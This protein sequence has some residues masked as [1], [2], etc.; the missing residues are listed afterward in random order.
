MARRFRSLRARVR[1][2]RASRRGAALIVVLLFVV[3]MGALALSATY[4]GSNATMISK[5]Y[6][7][8][9]DLR[10][11]AEAAL[12]M[13]KSKVNFD[14]DALPDSGYATFW[15]NVPVL[16]AD[17]TPVPG[18]K[19]SVY[20]GPSGSTSGQ[21]GRF[22]SIVAT[23]RDAQNNLAVRRLELVQESFAKFAYWSNDESN[24]GS[25]IY[26][27]NGD[28]LWGPV[29]SND[30]ISIAS[31]GATF[32]D[33]V[34]TAKS[35][36]GV[37]YGVF[38]KGYKTNQQA[39]KLPSTTTLS[40]LSSYAAL[41]GF[42]FAPAN[43]GDETLV[44]MRIEFV[45]LDLNGDGDS[46]DVDEGF[47]R[48]YRVDAA[49]INWL[50]ADWPGTT[51]SLVRNCGDWHKLRAGSSE[52]AFFPASVHN[53]SWFKTYLQTTGEMNATAA[54]NES[55][56]S[57]GTI[58]THANARCYLGGDPHLA[59]AARSNWTTVGKQVGGQDT[60]FTATEQ[61]GSWIANP[62]HVP[63][64]LLAV[65]PYDA[66][67]LFPIHRSLTPNSKGV[68]YAS[69]TVGVSGVLRGRITIYASGTVVILDDMRYQTDPAKG[70][71]QDILGLIAGA[72]VKVADNAINTP[73]NNGTD[74]RYADD[75]KDLNLHAV[76]MALNTSFGVQNYNSGPNDE[77]GC[78]GNKSGRGCLYLSG[79][80]IQLNRGAV[81]L[82][83]GE[84]FV[85][86]YSYDRCAVVQPPPYF[87]TTG[88]FTD[89][90][91]Y[92]L[93][94]VKFDVASLFKSITPDP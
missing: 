21:F 11:A 70:V 53:T 65:R 89:N 10:Y 87:P 44:R 63:A 9:A 56:A 23:A 2:R 4:L 8:E 94:P 71:C 30:D 49:N 36:S 84:G 80:I 25:T 55:V 37:S 61:Y 1:A 66:A 7:K 90:R 91:Y 29:W 34:G 5:S 77:N 52:L 38:S 24:S 13:G 20:G 3:A 45:A 32:H 19:I 93:D 72:N 22:S 92:E 6:D 78:E 64:K 14:A 67:Y 31:S 69:G 85:K 48:V 12:A 76:I 73:P 68:I 86:R 51:A 88:R 82:L 33:E 35:I 58:M 60:T 62:N 16:G 46:T 75:S 59:A 83:S 40:K 42:S 79:G 41:A 50:R 26:F 17:G 39:I 27:G 74:T 57:V 43:S 81:G 54:G 47:F 18:V 15:S 28:Q